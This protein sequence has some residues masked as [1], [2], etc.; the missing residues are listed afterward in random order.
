M[1]V[2]C[3]GSAATEAKKKAEV[4]DATFEMRE[5]STLEKNDIES[6]AYRLTVG[7]FA[8]CSNQPDK[9]V[10]AYPRLKSKHPLYG[11]F[12]LDRDITTRKSVEM[13]FVL[14]E[15][16]ETPPAE[17]KEKKDAGKEKNP[18]TP[19]QGS[20][21][22]SRYD[23]LYIDLNRDLDLTNDPVVRPMKNPPWQALPPWEVK[24]RRAFDY[25]NVDFDYGPRV[26]VRPFRVLPWLTGSDTQD[27]DD[28]YTMHF[29]APAARQGRIRIGSYEC[30]AL[31]LQSHSVTGRFDRPS[32]TLYFKTVGAA[33]G[34]TSD[35]FAGEMLCTVHKVD[36][37]LYT[38]S[39]TPLGDKLTVKPYRGDFGLMRIGSGK[40]DIKN[41]AFSGSLQSE[42]M[43]FTLEADRPWLG[44]TSPDTREYKVPVGDYV[45]AYL[46]IEYGKL[47]LNI[48]NNYH[49]DGKPRGHDD[50]WNYFIK[51]RKDKP[52][53]LDF[54]NKPDVLFASPAKDATFKPGDNVNVQAVLIDPPLDI[55]IRGLS[56]SSRK[57]K[58]TVRYTEGKE[59]KEYS[60]ERPLSLDPLV[61]ITDSAGKKIAEDPMP[62]G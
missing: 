35:G 2:P 31:L 39:A 57:K 14:D 21:K 61:T 55:M 1:L 37:Q 17:E 49:S 28:H 19:R 59:K 6:N 11:T 58:E 33:K 8:A 51:I 12:L 47:H 32:T 23:R 41:M 4:K 13:H 45:P 10:K 42:T 43:A 53:V 40:R 48:S 30:D 16:G 38:I 7:A 34:L 36:G 20:G 54:A 50:P 29:V 18:A 26:G 15:S 24:E 22:P 3:L 27:K 52:F 62:F 46:V 44:L 56:D 60:Y 25:I 9:A 5:V